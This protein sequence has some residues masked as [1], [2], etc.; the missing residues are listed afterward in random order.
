MAWALADG[1]V[2]WSEW[3]R[4]AGGR[5]MVGAWKW[6]AAGLQLC[7]VTCHSSELTKNFQELYKGLPDVGVERLTR[8][9][10]LT[11]GQVKGVDHFWKHYVSACT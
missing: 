4:W 2:G 9:I 7:R 8:G 6:E 1:E 5:S 3:G 11:I 10:P